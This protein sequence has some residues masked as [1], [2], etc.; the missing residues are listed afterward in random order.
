MGFSYL[1][2]AGMRQ[3]FNKNTFM[4]W[5]DLIRITWQELRKNGWRTFFTILGIVI[6]V[7]SIIIVVSLGEAAEELIVGEL[8]GLGSQTVLVAAGR[9]SKRAAAN[10]LP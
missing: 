4:L 9:R 6:G 3:V 8:S 5:R 7:G 10:P 1:M 2:S